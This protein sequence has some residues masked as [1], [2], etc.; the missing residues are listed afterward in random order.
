M[1]SRVLLVKFISFCIFLVILV[2]VEIVIEISA[3][4]INQ[5]TL[6]APSASGNDWKWS[7]RRVLPDHVTEKF[8][9]STSILFYYI[10]YIRGIRGIIS[11]GRG[12][13][14]SSCLVI[15]NSYIVLRNRP[16]PAK[17]DKRMSSRPAGRAELP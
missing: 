1:K 5:A 6:L 8:T 11:G 13:G 4:P 10:N 14:K 3:H 15:Q 12:K 9:T 7:G 17:I 16:S 2:L